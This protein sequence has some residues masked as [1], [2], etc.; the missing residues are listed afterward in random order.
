[1]NQKRELP[2]VRQLVDAMELLQV[3]RLPI[4]IGKH[5]D[6]ST[7]HVMASF[8]FLACFVWILVRKC[9]QP[10]ETS[11]VFFLCR[12]EVVITFLGPVQAFIPRKRFR[13]RDCDRQHLCIQT[14]CIQVL[15]SLF[16]V[17][18]TGPVDMGHACP[19]VPHPVMRSPIM[20]AVG[21]GLQTPAT[22]VVQILLWIPMVV[23][24]NCSLCHFS[25]LLSYLIKFEFSL[26]SSLI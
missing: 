13:S 7:A 4:K 2:F 25:F 14:P 16:Q 15:D 6:S 10:I 9:C 23:C 19:F 1:M 26:Y 5:L 11:R 12:F 24:I 20:F 3:D 8:Q 21:I 22:Q 18:V 17:I